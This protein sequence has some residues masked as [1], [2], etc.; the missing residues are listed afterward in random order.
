MSHGV[1]EICPEDINWTE[2]TYD[3]AQWYALFL[4]LLN[5]TFST[6]EVI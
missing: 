5:D 3:R 6:V 2:L 1:I 4:N